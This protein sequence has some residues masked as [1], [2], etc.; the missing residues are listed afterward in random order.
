[1]GK[2]QALGAPSVS[3]V[4]DDLPELQFIYRNQDGTPFGFSL[5][6]EHKRKG[7]L[8]PL[9]VPSGILD[10]ISSLL[11]QDV[12]EPP[13][14]GRF[15]GVAQAIALPPASLPPQGL[16]VGHFFP[17]AAHQSTHA[18]HLSVREV[19]K[20]LLQDVQ[21]NGED[22]KQKKS[23]GTTADTRP[24]TGLSPGPSKVRWY[25]YQV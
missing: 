3:T 14:G 15:G 2:H 22:L 21:R 1:M 24:G 10:Q 9:T 19:E 16:A 25:Q 6:K 17:L 11:A 23:S 13:V 8:R 7:A 18:D 20:H 4:G 5:V 12:K